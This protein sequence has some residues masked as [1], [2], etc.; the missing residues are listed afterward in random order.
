M[1]YRFTRAAEAT[2]YLSILD[3]CTMGY[4]VRNQISCHTEI[5]EDSGDIYLPYLAYKLSVQR[6]SAFVTYLNASVYAKKYISNT[7]IKGVVLANF[8]V[9]GTVVKH[10]ECDIFSQLKLNLRRKMEKKSPTT[11]T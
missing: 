3:Y 2:P 5:N 10:R 7:K 1:D 6:G 9:F 4:E 11:V 8:E